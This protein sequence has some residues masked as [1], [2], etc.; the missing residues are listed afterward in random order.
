MRQPW[1]W[2]QMVIDE[3][4]CAEQEREATTNKGGRELQAATGPKTKTRQGNFDVA[5]YTEMGAIEGNAFAKISMGELAMAAGKNMMV[6]IGS[7]SESSFF[8][9]DG[10]PK[11]GSLAATNQG[12]AKP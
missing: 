3:A 4:V 8:T 7:K 10:R 12:N 6:S 5:Q 9:V 2:V 11:V 1:R